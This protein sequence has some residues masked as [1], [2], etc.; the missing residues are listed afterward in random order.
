M[1][2]GSPPFD[3]SNTATNSESG[4]GGSNS[5]GGQNKTTGTK[6]VNEIN[7]AGDSGENGGLKNC[8]RIFKKLLLNWYPFDSFSF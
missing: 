3:N 8:L 4:N 1:R 2:S 5:R 7:S 6:E